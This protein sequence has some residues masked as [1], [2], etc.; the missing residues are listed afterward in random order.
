[1][2]VVDLKS[3]KTVGFFTGV[4]PPKITDVKKYNKAVASYE[5]NE[6]EFYV[7]RSM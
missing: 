2:G 4:K 7:S 1:V 3:A 5:K 6:T